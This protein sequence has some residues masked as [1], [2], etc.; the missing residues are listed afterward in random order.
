MIK[1]TKNQIYNVSNRYQ[2]LTKKVLT[3]CSAGL[4]RSATL[5]N[6]LIKEYGYN[7]RNCGT[8]ESYALIPIS[9]ALVTWADEIVFVN[10]ENYDFVKSE[11]EQLGYLNKCIILDIPDS[12]SFNDP[13]LINICREQYEKINKSKL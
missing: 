6:L 5:Q 12:Y 10:K 2:G 4:L 11:I 13:E 1:S 8:V 9:E 7:V 3:I